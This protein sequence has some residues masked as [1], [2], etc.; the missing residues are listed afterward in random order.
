MTRDNWGNTNYRALLFDFFG[1]GFQCM[2]KAM[3]SFY[4]S[5]W[6]FFI[7]SLEDSSG[8]SFLDVLDGRVLAARFASKYC[9]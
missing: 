9:C 8:K 5:Y 2:A 3:G 6:L 4:G 1:H 7:E